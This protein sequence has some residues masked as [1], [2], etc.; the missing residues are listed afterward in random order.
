VATRV[1]AARLERG[2]I[3]PTPLLRR[4]GVPGNALERG[5]RIDV[6]AQIRFLDIAGEASGDDFLGLTL[7]EDVD[8][9]EMGMLYY[10]AASCERAGDALRRLARYVRLGNEALQVELATEPLRIGLSYAGVSRHLD[11]HQMEFLGLIVVRLCR[12]LIGRNILPVDVQF[13]HHRSGDLRRF[14]RSFGCEV[15]FDAEADQVSYDSRLA[16]LGLVGADPFLNRLMVEHCEEALA[17][18]PSNVSPFRATVENA[19]APLLPHAE[20]GAKTV[21]K[22]LG[23]SERSFARRLAAEGLS[24]GGILDEMRRELAVRYL[25]E[26]GLQVSQIAWLLGFR[27]PSAFSHACRRWTGKSPS[28][29]RGALMAA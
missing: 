13:M 5:E 27:Q 18:R 9:R 6:A 29:Y 17:E 23:L 21:A 19:I 10:V 28:E 4:A 3:D 15:G 14:R 16:E 11:R 7:A 22:R 1:A 8:L 24:F 2:G 26:P 12:Q 20:A 25:E